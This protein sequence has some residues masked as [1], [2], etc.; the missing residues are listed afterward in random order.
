ME[1][2]GLIAP[3]VSSEVSLGSR[4]SVIWADTFD[5]ETDTYPCRI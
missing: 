5:R 2:A 1:E 4:T 3:G